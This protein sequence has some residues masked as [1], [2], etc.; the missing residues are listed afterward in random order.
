[1]KISSDNLAEALRKLGVAE[2][3]ITA[4]IKDAKQRD[5]DEKL[6]KEKKSKKQ[7]IAVINDP[8]NKLPENLS[9]WLFQQ[10]ED[11]ATDI[12]TSIKN[13][14]ASCKASSKKKADLLNSMTDIM[15]FTP[16]K[17][18]KEQHIVCKTKLPAPVIKTSI[19]NLI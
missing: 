19:N 17:F 9:V 3:T 12:V 13:A 11:S 15:E 18:F 7:W 14:A 6:P 8:N 1:M 2:A 4:A 16:S 5:D 10:D